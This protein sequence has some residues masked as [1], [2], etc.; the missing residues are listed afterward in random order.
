MGMSGTSHPP[1]MRFESPAG[2][3]PWGS[4]PIEESAFA[5]VQRPAAAC[6]HP[7]PS[8][9]FRYTLRASVDGD[10]HV[11]RCMATSEHTMARPVDAACLCDAVGRLT[12]PG[13]PGRRFRVTAVD[14]GGFRTANVALE[15]IQPGTEP[16]LR[17]LDESPALGRCMA[18][19]LPAN[20]SAVVTLALA[21]DGGVDDVRIDGDITTP[22]AIALARCL[23]QEL[24]IVPLPC[25]PP[26][27]DALQVRLVVNP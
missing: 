8:L 16:W 11:S 26:G 17:R 6:A 14:E 13:R 20:L 19:D 25:R 22:P 12:L 7:D 23:V 1:P 4:S 2:I 27:V 24:R 21:P 5:D 3:G 18:A 9:G 15:L 10:G